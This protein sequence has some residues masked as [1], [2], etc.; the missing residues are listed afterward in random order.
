MVLGLRAGAHVQ[1]GVGEYVADV[2]VKRVVAVVAGVVATAATEDLYRTRACAAA[3]CENGTTTITLRR[4]H[5]HIFPKLLPVG[6]TS[7]FATVATSFANKHTHT[8]THTRSKTQ[9]HTH[10]TYTQYARDV[11]AQKN[12]LSQT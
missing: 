1:R 8:E 11:S 4:T 10:N 7:C 3:E 6:E 9:Q 12:V 5:T 2:Q